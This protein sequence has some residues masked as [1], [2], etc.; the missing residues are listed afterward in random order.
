M[1]LQQYNAK[2]DFKKTA[3]PAGA[4]PAHKAGKALSFVVQKH[5]ASRLHYDFRLELDGVL[6]S[7]AVPKGPSLDPSH[8]ALAVRVEDHPL[9]YASFEGT[10]PEGQYGGGTVAVWDRGR[11]Q[12][13]GDPRDGLKSGKLTFTLDGER[14]HGEWALVQ[15]HGRGEKNW[16]L[17]KKRDE[18]ANDEPMQGAD[19]IVTGRTLEEIAR[20]KK[21]KRKSKTPRKAVWDSSRK[22]ARVTTAPVRTKSAKT[23]LPTIA[24]Q[25]AVLADEAPVGENWS[26]EI[27]YDGY[28]LI[29]TIQNGNVTL[30]T[31]NGHDWTHR[32]KSIADSLSKLKVKRAILDGEAVVLDKEGRSDFQALQMMLKARE[33]ATPV[34]FAFDL[35]HLEGED[36]RDRPLR[37]RVKTLQTLMKQFK[38]RENVRLSERLD[39]AGAA[40]LKLACKLGLEGIISKRLDAPYVS[41]RDPSWLKVKCGQRQEFVVVGFTQPERSRVGIGALLLG[42][43]DEKKRLVYAGRVGTGFDTKLLKD[44]RV[45]L[46]KQ[47]VKTSPLDVDAP[48]RERRAATWVKPVNVAEISFTGWT[49]DGMLRHPVFVGLRSDKSADAVVREKAVHTARITKGNKAKPRADAGSV[50]QREPKRPKHLGVNAP[51]RQVTTRSF[52]G[53]PPLD[54]KQLLPRNGKSTEGENRN[55]TIAG[56]TLSHPDKVLYPDVG[57]TKRDVADYIHLA[58]KWMLPHVAHRPLALVRCPGGRAQKC[59]FQR[60]YTDTISDAIVPV[61][62]AEK[63]KKDEHLMLEDERGLIA[64]VQ[65]GV[66]EI[67]TWN[68][69]ADAIESPDQLVFDLDPGDGVPW[70]RVVDGARL[71]RRSLEKLRLPV[72]LKTSGGKGLHLVVPLKPTI[73]WETA[74]AFSGDVAR[75]L[76]EES[77]LF[78]ANMRKDLRQGKIFIDF[79]RNGRSSTS[80]APYSTRA[81]E[82]APVSMPISWEELGKLTSA[83]QF[84]VDTARRYLTHRRTDPWQAFGRSRVD[85]HKRLRHGAAA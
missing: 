57:K 20:G 55:T 77:D 22:R 43:H 13:I 33:K 16:L 62:V 72:F 25:L 37:E 69:T 38:S 40:V 35:L 32:F 8:K 54:D 42:Y 74:K 7:W 81:R 15:M 21:G 61:D 85:L 67:H 30:T 39:A 6:L 27:K 76:A 28:R 45:M 4:K 49:R 51:P 56:V 24:P 68:C 34:Y 44:L 9:D 46:E 14:L 78:V 58:A 17:M 19:S 64:L 50:M 41:R 71:I 10:I 1:G 12:P 73:D 70:K 52:V 48:A 66:L 5:D 29:A 53:K 80:V 59:F 83:S 2:R 47:A 31:R 84:T 18:F 36:L 82:G 23:S 63:G 60:N 26:H 3:E 65:M 79:H 11:W 75:T